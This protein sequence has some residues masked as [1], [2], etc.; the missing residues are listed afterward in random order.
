MSSNKLNALIL[1]FATILLLF[2]IPFFQ[3]KTNFLLLLI[4][5]YYLAI[6]IFLYPK[7]S[8]F[9]LLL[10][11]PCLDIYTN[12]PVLS[13]FNFSLNFSSI[14]AIIT[15]I[16][17]SYI[18]IKNHL[19]L[20]EVPL[21]LPVVFFLVV[22]LISSLFSIDRLTSLTEWVR[23]LSIFSL[24]LLG[25][26]FIKTEKDLNKL[27]KIIILSALIPSA[28]AIFQ[29]FSQTGM[30]LPFE[31]IY[32]RIFGTFAHPNLFAYYL[33]IPVSILIY[34]YFVSDKKK[35]ESLFLVFLSAVFFVVL[36][37]TFTR[38]AWLALI[39][40]IFIIG[41]VKYRKFLFIAFIILI[42]SY[43]LITPI[44]SRVDDLISNPTSS[45]TWRLGLWSDSLNY[46]KE[47]LFFGQGT[48]TAKEY[49][50]D[51][52]GPQ[53]GSSD[54]H[55]DYLKISLENGVLGLILYMLLI[56]TLIYNLIKRYL[57][58]SQLNIKVFMLFLIA[59]SISFYIMSFVDNV[60]RNTAMQWVFW[61]LVGAGFG[62]TK[63][64]NNSFH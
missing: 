54:P 50:L 42:L 33:I 6:L 23:L 29:Y 55:N 4:I 37:L 34:T 27:I 64:K 44:K 17:T 46:V 39:I 30:S 13:F 58:A 60:L 59:L 56:T 49:I 19:R 52:R 28:L 9:L 18:I 24:Y 47:R 40:F 48:G 35:I 16:F 53:F 10:I 31:G 61:S 26:L 32:N 3:I 5:L 43:L 7:I 62:L 12:E 14:T 57:S 38:G 21:F 41:I 8:L 15:L 36:I 22:T 45:I 2:I 1:A 25:Y 63:L 51:K 20:K 11:R